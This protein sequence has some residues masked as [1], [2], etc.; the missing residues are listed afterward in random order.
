MSDKSKELRVIDVPYSHNSPW[1]LSRRTFLGMMAGSGAVWAGEGATSTVGSPAGSAGESDPVNLLPRLT[2]TPERVAGIARP[3]VDLN[4]TWRFNPSPAA[5]FW[6]DGSEVSWSDIQVP[7]EWTMQGFSV[8]PGQA[9]GYRL[10]FPVPADWAGHRIKV[11]FDA[12]YSKAEVWMNGMPVGSHLG[13]FTPFEVDASDAILPGKD[14]VLVLGVASESLADILTA[15]REMVGH[16]MGGIIRKVR[17]FAVPEVNISSLHVDTTFDGEFRNATMH[18]LLDVANE[19]GKDVKDAEIQFGLREHGPDGKSVNLDPAAVKFRTIKAGEILSQ[20]I[21]IPVEAP[22]KWD[23]EHP[24]LYVLDCELRVGDQRYSTERRFGFRQV[25]IKDGRFLLN[26]QP[27]RLR[28]VVRQDSHPLMGRTVP[29]EVQ[30]QDIDW[31]LWA[32]SNNAYTCA[33]LPDEEFVNLCDEAG[34]YVMDEPGTCWVLVGFD[35]AGNIWKSEKIDDPK[36]FPFLLQP[37]LEMIERDRSHPSVI[38]WMLAD[39]ST[40][41]KNFREVLKIVRVVDPS[42]PVHMAYDPECG[43]QG[44]VSK[45]PLDLG[46]WHYPDAKMFAEAIKSKR[47]VIFDQSTHVYCANVSELMADPGLR[48]DWGRQYASFWEKI[49]ET[50]SIL[51]EQV[52]NFTD[53]VFLMPSGEVRGYGGWGL[54]DYWRRAKPDLWH[55]KKVHTPVKIHEGPIPLPTAG[56]PL[57]VPVENRYDFSDLSELRIVWSLGD[58]SGT[59]QAHVPPHG[60]GTITIRPRTS[61]LD[62]RT[63]SLKFFRKDL[64]LDAYKLPIGIPAESGAPLRSKSNRKIEMVQTKETIVA[65]GE[66]FEWVMSRRTGEIINALVKGRSVIVGGPVLMVLPTKEETHTSGYPVPRPSS[67]SP[68]NVTCREWKATSVSGKHSADAVEIAVVGQ[69]REAAGSYMVR[70]DGDGV[71]TVSYRFTYTDAEKI[72]PRQIGI[73]FYTPRSCDTL[74]W[75]RKAQWSVYPDDHIGRPDGVAKALSDASLLARGGDWMEVAFREKPTWP[76]YLDSNGLGTR[77]FRATRRNILYASLKDSV[78]N[79]VAI[80]SDGTHHTRSYLDGDRIGLLVAWY[81]GPG[82]FSFERGMCEIV[83]AQSMP[84]EKGTEIKDTVRLSLVGHPT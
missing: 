69:Y 48:D 84:F 43:Q 62:G 24:N 63:L 79:G 78:G 72:T 76:W 1:S 31:M 66:G 36:Y 71:A 4:G 26:G 44:P 82:G 47:P 60:S 81:S 34:L 15:G 52:F 77:D 21:D 22:R 67:Y 6:K 12:V 20:V 83:G 10:R 5:E 56:Q 19:G 27:I 18:V 59:I 65:K 39:E 30:R 73:V 42:R 28:G 32:N 58:E 41:G 55:V 45:S 37:V 23:A 25:N 33:F 7:G 16:A 80:L 49:W 9:G 3:R 40:C 8:K 38:T 70:V 13:A 35:M 50:R 74:T 17:V 54:I 51:G 68:F 57:L 14:N 46:S 29:P 53:D 11:R 61:D 64:M 2:P 75:K